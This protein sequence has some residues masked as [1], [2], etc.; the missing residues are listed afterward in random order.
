MKLY[1]KS[2]GAFQEKDF[3]MPPK[4]YR[5]APFWAWNTH[6]TE[7][8]IQ[9]QIPVFHEMG[10][11][12]FF[13]HCRVGLDTEYLSGEYFDLVGK[14]IE[15]AREEGM[16]PWLYDEDRWPSGSGGGKVT[17]QKEYR[18]RFL[19]ME[20]RNFGPAESE[21]FQASAKAI[22]GGERKH[23]ISFEI[24]LDE[25][26]YLEDYRIKDLKDNNSDEKNIW[27]CYL[28]L[29]GETPWYNNQTYLNTLDK[30]A[31][32][33]FLDLTHEEYYRRFGEDFGREIYGIFTDEPQTS[34]KEQF[35]DPF[36]RK[37][38]TMPFT[39]DFEETYRKAFGESCLER[40]P[41]IF[42]ESRHLDRHVRMNYHK[43]VN[44]RFCE[45]FTDQVGKW[46]SEH[47]IYLTG[48]VM[49]EWTLFMQT[50]AA[51]DVMRPL[52]YFGLPGVD[53][54]CDRRELSTVKQAASVAHQFGREGV[55]CEIYGVTGWDFDF[56][57]HK[58]AGDWQAAL[59][60]TLRV[61]H[62]TWMSMKGEAKRDYPASIGYQSPWY[63]K[64]KVIEDYF[65]RLNVA[66]TRGKP[67]VSIGV[68]HPIESYWLQWGNQEQT[69]LNRMEKEHRFEELIRWLL[70]NLLDFDFISE[71]ILEEEP[72]EEKEEDEVSVPQFKVGE[73]NYST[74]IIPGCQTLRPSTLFRI[75]RFL[76]AGGRVLIL[77]NMPEYLDGVYKRNEIEK[78]LEK[79]EKIEFSETQLVEALEKDRSVEVFVE[80]LDGAD[81]TKQKR[82]ERQVRSD[83]LFYQLR[84]DGEEKWLFLAHVDSLVNEDICHT[85]ELTIKIKG[86]YQAIRL[87]GMTGSV[88]KVSV[89]WHRG[90]TVI[91]Q[92]G[93]QQDS[94]LFRL[95]LK[96]NTFMELQG[97]QCEET[98]PD[99]FK[100]GETV[101]PPFKSVIKENVSILDLAEY[102]LDDESWNPEEEILRIDNILRKRLDL[103]QRTEAYAQPWAQERQPAVHRVR[104]RY[105]I[106]AGEAFSDL[107]L[108]LEYQPGMEITLNGKRIVEKAKEFYV[109]QDIEKYILGVVQKGENILE[110][111]VPFGEGT[112]LEAMYIL[113]DFGVSLAGR[114][115]WLNRQREILSFGNVVPQGLPFYSDNITYVSEIVTEVGTLWVEIPHYRGAV[116]EIDLDGER[117]GDIFLQPYRLNCGKVSA[118]THQLSIKLYGN[119]NNTFGALHNMDPTETWK[120]PLLWRTEGSKWGYEYQ[121]GEFGILSAPI[122]WTE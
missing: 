61:P 82:R 11:G 65:S 114:R 106:F 51:G 27:D 85:E 110:V 1:A 122:Y 17:K 35:R 83:N 3:K 94:Y 77:G 71:A 52:K 103:P 18:S 120:G 32:R 8:K 67:V 36:E 10:M 28:E 100:K 75:E 69:G 29:S 96:S 91:T 99:Q 16:I 34:H 97:E 24:I 20:P 40:L 118:G 46:C 107:K 58:I 5:G 95:I 45:A 47:Q 14:G 54:L 33:R 93:F 121:P 31:V 15:K 81:A 62:L 111:K 98:I 21:G 108:A 68:L 7:E 26:G 74:L 37:A 115:Q 41:E 12:G 48:H 104:L 25:E 92:R 39:D 70:Y 78:R 44:Q 88:Q 116:L 119:R 30:K 63:K 89:S 112:N 109:D 72:Y 79:A 117:K 49:N 59:G 102:A 86:E 9:E 23:L 6:V 13:M 76:K 113:G 43:H 4:E 53:M 73:M 2:S 60:V 101:P 42:W 57:K 80:A 55:A 87:D 19:V 56:R 90:W 22:R 66:L 50:V 105:R 38:I 84:Q 64:Y